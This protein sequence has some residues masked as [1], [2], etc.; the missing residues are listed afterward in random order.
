MNPLLLI[1]LL[2]PLL[3]SAGATVPQSVSPP[4]A[5][6][7][8]AQQ[9]D[10]AVL[11]ALLAAV[12]SAE[13]SPPQEIRLPR[14]AAVVAAVVVVGFFLILATIAGLLIVGSERLAPALAVLSVGFGVLAS[15][16][17]T[18]VDFLFGSSWGS[19]EKDVRRPSGGQGSLVPFPVPTP[20]PGPVIEPA[21][22]PEPSPTEPISIAGIGRSTDKST[23]GLR[24]DIP[25]DG[26]AASIRYNNPGAQYPS[27]RAAAFGQLGYGVIGGGHKIALFPHPV[28]GAAS[29]FDLLSRNYVGMQIGAAGAKWTGDNGFGIPGYDNNAVLTAE[30][31]NDPAKAIPVLK[32]MAKRE[33][34]YDSPLTD[35]QWAQAHA[36]F[37]AGSADAWLSSLRPS[38]SERQTRTSS[39]ISVG[40]RPTGADIVAL[41]RTRLGERYANVLV[42]KNDANWHGPWDCAEFASWL[43]YQ[44]AG[45][46]Y[47][48]TN[49]D[50]PPDK[51]DAYTGA[52]KNDVEAKGKMVSVSEAAGT[53]G[54]FLLRYPPAPGAM[55]HIVVSDGQGGTIEAASSST[56]VVSGKVSGRRWDTGVLVPGVDYSSSRISVT[57]PGAIYTVDQPNMNPDKIREIQIALNSK[58]IDLGLQHVD[59]DGEYG[60]ETALAVA[61]FQ[62]IRGLIPDGE[63][64]PD[65][66]AALGIT[67]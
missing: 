39:P 64:G 41:A 44:V 8:P 14:S 13:P 11:T 45:I 38:D 31:V 60:D 58:G 52:W 12:R 1:Q 50:D 59:V 67:L 55:G 61:A 42:P 19:R 24:R 23:S 7:A 36:M 15:K 28:N 30:M 20:S 32:A 33:A 26:R 56:G 16:F 6:A 63:V 51:A 18:V 37:L 49:D 17:G 65:T 25:S 21:P 54:A 62:R 40:P 66:A 46:I 57:G 2:A 3:A 9:I 53:P 4:N 35:Q 29:N 5:P 22:A 43:V 47:G 10:P 27:D 48:C 34:G